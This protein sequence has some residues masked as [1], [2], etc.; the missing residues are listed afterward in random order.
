MLRPGPVCLDLVKFG[1]ISYS[2]VSSH[3]VWLDIVLCDWAG[4]SMVWAGTH[5]GWLG[6]D[7]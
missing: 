5:G 3:I 1:W 6:V 2:M 4:Y 7:V